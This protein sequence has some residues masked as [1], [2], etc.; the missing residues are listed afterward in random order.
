MLA[1]LS[2]FGEAYVTGATLSGGEENRVEFLCKSL[3]SSKYLTNKATYLSWAK[4]FMK[5]RNNNSRSR[6]S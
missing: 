5:V 1:S 2:L 4:F 6:L 3:W